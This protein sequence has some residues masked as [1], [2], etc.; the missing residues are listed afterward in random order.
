[1]KQTVIRIENVSKDYKLYAQ[2]FDRV[3]EI[4]TG[5]PC[6]QLSAALQD[7]S[8]Q[9]REGEVVGVVGR[10]GAG[11]STLL[12]VLANT[13]QVST[14]TVDVRGRIAALLELG[15]SFHPEM[16]GHDNIYLYCSI[17]GLSKDE[18]DRIYDDIVEFSG[19]REFIHRPVKTYSSGMFVRL[20]FAAATHVDPDIL[21][22][23]EA[24]SVG[25]G[26]FARRS[27]ER[28]MKFKEAGKTIFFCSHS[29][30]QVEA[31]CDRVIWIEEGRIREDGE[32][33]GVIAHY[34]EFL[35]KRALR[36]QEV[37]DA[38]E[39]SHKASEAAQIPVGQ[40]TAAVIA[41]ASGGEVPRIL[42]LSVLVDGKPGRSHLVHSGRS[43]LE[44]RVH[45][46]VA[47]GIP[48][49]SL[50]VIISSGDGNIVTS[51]GSVNDG[52]QFAP[53]A[54]GIGHA[55]L[56]FPS[57]ALLRGYYLLDVYLMCERG[58]H[59]YEK[60]KLAAE[61]NVDQDGMARGYVELPHRWQ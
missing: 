38:Q 58:I 56:L 19:I 4:L 45:Y 30:Y 16:S 22:I 25:D 29:L 15:A 27:F 6:H 28:I 33:A 23:D 52:V 34:S 43:T 32:P 14:G 11:K 31:L 26:I 12:K 42:N 54:E 20:A 9:V 59:V 1:M 55:T 53:D 3:R 49:P 10:N 18:T 60:V 48:A 21:I 8:L 36:Q 17:Q 2:D 24:L 5:K 35:N 40:R 50:G 13:L 57:L 39:E 46:H 41:P 47:R 61:L 51:A 44:L 37:A 7:V